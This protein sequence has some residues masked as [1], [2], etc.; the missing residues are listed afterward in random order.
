MVAAS[1]VQCAFDADGY[2]A[3]VVIADSDAKYPYPI[4]QGCTSALETKAVYK[5][6]G[7]RLPPVKQVPE[8][9]ESIAQREKY[10]ADI[11]NNKDFAAAK[12]IDPKLTWIEF[13]TGG[14]K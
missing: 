14:L 6:A 10:F 4:P 2:L 5:D 12:L 11:A 9:P 3:M 8:S 7:A 13:V 1:L